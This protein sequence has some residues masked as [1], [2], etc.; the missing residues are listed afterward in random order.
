MK[1]ILFLDLDGTIIEPASGEKFPVFI[2]DM[3][4]KKDVLNAIKNF[5]VNNKTKY[6]FIITNQGGIEKGY[7]RERF[8]IRKIEFIITCLKDY[9][10]NDSLTIKYQYCKSEIVNHQYRKP[11]TGMLKYLLREFISNSNLLDKSCMLMVGDASGLEG[12]FA[13]SDKKTAENFGIEYIDISDFINRF[14]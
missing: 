2:G 9:L 8:F 4:F 11:N 14:K 6:L 1:H 12:Q 3:V 13:D 5:V 7:I 10:K